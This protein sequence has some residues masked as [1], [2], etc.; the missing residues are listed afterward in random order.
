MKE[1]ISLQ[2]NS[3]AKNIPKE[4]GYAYLKAAEKGDLAGVKAFVEKYGK[5]AIDVRDRDWS[6]RNEPLWK[7]NQKTALRI[8]SWEKHTDIVKYLIE[9]GADVNAP[10]KRGYTPLMV[11]H[12]PEMAVLLLDAGAKIDQKRNDGGT[13][14][15][16]PTTAEMIKFLVS[17]GANVE[18]RNK[19]GET[20]LMLAAEGN[21]AGGYA[22][23]AGN[24][25]AFL[26]AGADPNARDHQ[27][28]TA[29]MHAATHAVYH[30][31]SIDEDEVFLDRIKLLIERGADP[32]LRDSNGDTAEMIARRHR[33]ELDGNLEQQK[34]VGD[35]LAEEVARRHAK[36]R[37]LFIDGGSQAIAVMKPLQ[38]KK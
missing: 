33:P 28:R 9:N 23:V 12:D 31:G 19:E 7:T 5:Q 30:S 10:D 26:D 21:R 36:V 29:L 4:D 13:A 27:G 38:L 16:W 35:F 15:M 1:E 25:N 22:T 20:A 17:R 8:A 34:E 2:F 11:S 32:E 14:L 3:A 24:L 37:E 18:A 6:P